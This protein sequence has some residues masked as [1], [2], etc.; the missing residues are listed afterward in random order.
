M[1]HSQRDSGMICVAAVFNY[2]F[3]I[4]IKMLLKIRFFCIKIIAMQWYGGLKVFFL[5]YMDCVW[6]IVCAL[7]CDGKKV[8]H[9]EKFN[10]LFLYILLISYDLI[11]YLLTFRLN[12]MEWFWTLL[13]ISKN[14]KINLWA[15]FTILTSW[16][17]GMN[18][19]FQYPFAWWFE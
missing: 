12:F 5:N 1:S 6:Y 8:L 17:Q 7:W 18:F 2:S 9:G 3:E 10:F 19:I 14:L 11:I 15:L 16:I 4:A 13:F